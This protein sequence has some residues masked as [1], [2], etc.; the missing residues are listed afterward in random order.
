MFNRIVFFKF[1]DR[2]ELVRLHRKITF[3]STHCAVEHWLLPLPGQPGEQLHASCGEPLLADRVDDGDAQLARKL[4]RTHWEAQ[5]W[6]QSQ[7]SSSTCLQ[8]LQET[9]LLV[10][11]PSRP[12][13]KLPARG[14]ARLPFLLQNLKYERSSKEHRN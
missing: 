6:F 5:E 13:G 9:R 12:C 11:Q 14:S 10:R 1:W 2:S 7:A 4:K 3:Q 8:Q